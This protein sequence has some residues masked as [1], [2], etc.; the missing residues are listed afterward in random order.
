MLA[1]QI[2]NQTLDKHH[3]RC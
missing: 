1:D 3:E 2:D